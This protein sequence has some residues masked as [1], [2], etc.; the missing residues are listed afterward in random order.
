MI[1]LVMDESINSNLKEASSQ[2]ELTSR[3][4]KKFASKN[5]GFIDNLEIELRDKKLTLLENS[6]YILKN[7][8]DMEKNEDHNR[9]QIN[10]PNF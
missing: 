4:L 5:F 6:Y 1:Y 2:I 9:K 10:V 8:F 3:L 7:I